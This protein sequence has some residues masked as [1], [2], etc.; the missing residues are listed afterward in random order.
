MFKW[1]EKNK[2]WL[3]CTKNTI[4]R[5]RRSRRKKKKLPSPTTNRKICGYIEL[6]FQHNNMGEGSEKESIYINYVESTHHNRIYTYIYIVLLQR[7][8][9][10]SQ[11]FQ[12]NLIYFTISF[13]IR[14][15]VVCDWMGK[16]ATQYTNTI[17]TCKRANFICSR[18]P[19]TG[20]HMNQARHLNE[21]QYKYPDFYYLS[22]WVCT[23]SPFVLW[24]QVVVSL[25]HDIYSIFSSRIKDNF[26][27]YKAKFIGEIR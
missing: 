1:K 18:S 24:Y 15:R 3:Q 21:L 25:Q 7:W 12:S 22:S 26:F 23:S 9:K 19:F 4:Y 17:S 10:Y 2:N 8:I 11:F 20:E 13:L 14:I 27:F 16:W 6:F 5:S